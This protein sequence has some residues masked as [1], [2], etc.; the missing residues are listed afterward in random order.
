[1]MKNYSKLACLFMVCLCSC[2]TKLHD[3]RAKFG[4]G[5]NEGRNALHL[6]TVEDTFSIK[7]DISVEGRRFIFV[8]IRE[9]N[10]TVPAFLRKIILLNS[11]GQ[12]LQSEEDYYKNPV[13]AKYLIVQHDYQNGTTNIDL[14]PISQNIDDRVISLD[15]RQA[16]SIHKSWNIKTNPF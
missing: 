2:K 1:M 14:Q 7:E 12:K 15:N 9:E 5:Q 6:V 4:T 16:D 13:E 8:N 11:S 10:V 3:I